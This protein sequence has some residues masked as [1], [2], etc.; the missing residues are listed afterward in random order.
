RQDFGFVLDVGPRSGGKLGAMRC[1]TGADDL[2]GH[3]Q[4]AL[5]CEMPAVN[6]ALVQ[7][8]LAEQGAG[9]A[10]RNRE[11]LVVPVEGQHL[12]V[13]SEQ[14]LRRRGDTQSRPADVGPGTLLHR[15]AKVAGQQ[16]PAET[17]AA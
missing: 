14:G 6:E 10:L 8:V 17:M 5:E 2:V 16:L 11:G 15:C 3:L 4:M 7:A 12:S 9:R 1:A 13:R